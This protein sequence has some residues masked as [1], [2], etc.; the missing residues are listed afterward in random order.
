MSK[1]YYLVVD[2]D[3]DSGY[4]IFESKKE[5]EKALS[6]YTMEVAKETTAFPEVIL[7]NISVFKVSNNIDTHENLEIDYI[8][9]SIIVKVKG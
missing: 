5:L 3:L 7:D 1:T 4:G 8:T 2:N 9:N 6:Q